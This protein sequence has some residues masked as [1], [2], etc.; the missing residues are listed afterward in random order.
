MPELHGGRTDALEV[1]PSLWGG[2][3]L[4]RGGAGIALVGSH[5]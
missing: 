1:L 2:V 3:G 4:V 5:A